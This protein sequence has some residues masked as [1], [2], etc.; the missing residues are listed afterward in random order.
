MRVAYRYLAGTGARERLNP[1]LLVAV[2]EGAK[3]PF[4]K[5]KTAF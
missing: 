5:K 4:V 1:A 3:P 2:P